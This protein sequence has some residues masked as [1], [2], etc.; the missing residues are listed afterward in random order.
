[1]DRWQQIESLFEHAIALALPD[2]EE[3]LRKA[4]ADDLDLYREVWA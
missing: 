4:C 2:R 3:Y 1:V